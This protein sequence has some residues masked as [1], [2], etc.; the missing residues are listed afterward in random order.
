[1]TA[2]V[3]SRREFHGCQFHG[4]RFRGNRLALVFLAFGLATALVACGGS[5]SKA[6]PQTSVPPTPKVAPKKADPQRPEI[7]KVALLVPMSGP[8][9]RLGKAMLNAA[10]L[11]VQEVAGK[12]FVLLPK[13]TRGTPGGAAAAAEEALNEGATLILGPLLSSSVSAVK[14]IAGQRGVNMLAFSSDSSVAAPGAFVMGFLPSEQVDRVLRY[15][16]VEKGNMRVG[17]FAPD[18]AYGQLVARETQAAAARH[19][20]AV[21][22]TGFYD[23]TA[24]DVS[25]LSATVKQFAADR[26][27]GAGETGFNTVMLAEGG[28]RLLKVAP[29]LPYHNIRP[30]QVQYMGTG[31]WDNPIVFQEPNLVGAV[32]A[33][34]PPSARTAFTQKY[35]QTFNGTPPRLATLAYDA[36]AL[37]AVLAKDPGGA[38]FSSLRLTDPNGFRGADGIFRLLPSGIVQRGLAVLQIQDG[39][40]F[41]VVSPP[42]GSFQTLT[43]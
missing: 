8:H 22:A 41:V 28:L 18:N 24:S 31:L 14:P 35:R 5:S 43:Q 39:G 10:E 26:W 34:P 21:V 17:I 7:A 9:A 19:G 27:K 3:P 23:T 36:T 37:A 38:D 33:A 29:L 30:R 13:D 32:F 2:F 25:T 42:A 40:K 11:A 12:D 16:I 6:P 15:S 1:M 4:S 20:A